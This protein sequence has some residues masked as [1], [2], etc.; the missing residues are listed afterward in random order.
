M[1]DWSARDLQA[2]EMRQGLG[3]AKGK[4]FATSLGPVLVT[5]D[6][7]P[8]AAEGRPTGAMV[9]RVDGVEWSRGHLGSLHFTWGEL[10]AHAS[11]STVLRPGDVIGSG[12]VGTG[13]H[14]R[15]Q[16]GPR[17]GPLPVAAARAGGRAGDRGHRRAAQPGRRLSGRRAG[18]YAARTGGRGEPDRPMTTRAKEPPGAAAPDRRR[19]SSSPPVC[20]CCSWPRPSARSGPTW[21]RGAHLSSAQILG[22]VIVGGF[23]ALAVLGA[24]LLL[25]RRGMV[26]FPRRPVVRSCRGGSGPS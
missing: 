23:G 25:F 11:R 16:P 2:R 6:E 10:I 15:A 17:A 14:P 1:N 24:W 5:P 21:V 8:G 22:G 7:L 19:R 3:P 9:A 12:T 20:S 26:R 4:D 18:R 13:L